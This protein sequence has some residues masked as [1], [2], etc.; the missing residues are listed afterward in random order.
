MRLPS[1]LAPKNR[2]PCP[3][4]QDPMAGDDQRDRIF[5]QGLTDIARSLMTRKAELVCMDSP[6]EETGFELVWGFSCQELFWAYRHFFVRSGK[7]PSSSRRL[8]SGFPERAEGVKGP[9]R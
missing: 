9:K 7:G 2:Q 1:R 3:G 4:R 5:R 8:R 6:L